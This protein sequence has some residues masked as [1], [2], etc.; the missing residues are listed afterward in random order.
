MGQAYLTSGQQQA[1]FEALDRVWK[2]ARHEGTDGL[3]ARQAA[4]SAETMFLS[5]AGDIHR[6]L[7]IL[8]SYLKI[9]PEDNTVRV[10]LARVKAQ[11][12][13]YDDAVEPYLEALHRD[14]QRGLRV[15]LAGTYQ[16]EGLT[17]LALATYRDALKSIPT[18]KAGCVRSAC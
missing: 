15:E 13:D 6:A 16:Q 10:E 11:A 18:T 4:L 2:Q 14:P 8:D 12:R 3:E 7:Q 9:H 5:S 1:G 17:D